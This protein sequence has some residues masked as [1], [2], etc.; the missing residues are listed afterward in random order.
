M[1]HDQLLNNE[2]KKALLALGDPTG[3]TAFV[4][5]DIFADLLRMGLLYKRS[6]GSYDVTDQGEAVYKSL[7]DSQ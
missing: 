2:Q 1:N 4:T 6:D 7:C 3:E 5:H